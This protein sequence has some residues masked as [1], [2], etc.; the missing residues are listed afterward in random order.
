MEP[1][2]RWQSL[3]LPVDEPPDAVVVAAMS[4]AVRSTQKRKSLGEDLPNRCSTNAILAAGVAAVA[5]IAFVTT[6]TSVPP[7]F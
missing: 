4:V 2:A 5:S 6:G 7:V 3:R 1:V